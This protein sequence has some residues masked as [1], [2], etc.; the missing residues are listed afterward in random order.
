MDLTLTPAEM[1]LPPDR[2]PEWRPHQLLPIQACLN[3]KKKYF[4]LNAPT[5]T[6]KSLCAW[7]VITASGQRGLVNTVRRNLQLQYLQLPD[8]DYLWGKHN[9]RCY[10]W[11][12]DFD[13][14]SAPCSI[15]VACNARTQCPYFVHREQARRA[16]ILVS[17]YY[18]TLYEANYVGHWTTGREWGICDEAHH[19]EDVLVDFVALNLRKRRVTEFLAWPE[20]AETLTAWMMWANNAY[21]LLESEWRGRRAGFN[22]DKITDAAKMDLGQVTAYRQFQR[23]TRL[24]Q[25]VE[26]LQKCDMNWYLESGYGGVTIKP[27]WG[28]PFSHFLFDHFER[29]LAMSATLLRGEFAARI[30]GVNP[31]D[32]EYMETKSIFPI[33]NRWVYYYPI[34]NMALSK[35]AESFPKVL[36]AIDM[37]LA[38][39]PAGR[40]LIHAHSYSLAQDIYEAS[41]YGKRAGKDARMFMHEPGGTGTAEAVE[42]MLH[43]PRPLVAVSP[44]L[45]EGVDLPGRLSFQILPVVPWPSLGD[46]RVRLRL[47]AAPAWYSY[48][49]AMNFAQA[50]GRGVRTP[51]DKVYSYVLDSQF[52]RFFHQ[53]KSFFPSHLKESI[54]WPSK[55]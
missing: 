5:G 2:F 45:S 39:Y 25:T 10:L 32:T 19:I 8:T 15:G 18:M 42:R 47:E 22:F 52:G 44:N 6:G 35:R 40:G 50:V 33:E 37:I 53:A 24:K 12:D 55:E 9:E 11:P 43:D 29:V 3:S 49:T 17:N 34:A 51:T 20:D 26:G 31:D 27:L 36:R 54:R 23:L 14:E 30:M 48:Q 41:V 38:R 13:V 46:I 4:L 1:G 16:R 7:S 28:A 21:P